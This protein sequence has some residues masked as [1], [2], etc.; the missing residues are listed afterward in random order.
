MAMGSTSRVVLNDEMQK[1]KAD[2]AAF[3]TEVKTFM[4][5]LDSTVSTLLSSGFQGEAA[6]G[7]KEFYDKNVAAFMGDNGTFDQ[8]LAMFDKEGDGLFDSIEK[9]LIGGEGL[10]PSLGENNRNL[11]QSDGQT[12]Q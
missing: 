7:F 6:N 3:R 1:A 10:D 4:Q 9:T 11:G 5:E 8:Y 2:C 12:Q